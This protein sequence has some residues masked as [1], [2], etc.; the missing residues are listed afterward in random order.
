[1]SRPGYLILSSRPEPRHQLPST[2][3]NHH[4]HHH[5]NNP[6]R[7]FCLT[8]RPPICV[9]SSFQARASLPRLPRSY[10]NRGRSDLSRHSPIK[11]TLLTPTSR[12]SILPSQANTSPPHPHSNPPSRNRVTAPTIK[13]MGTRPR[14]SFSITRARKKEKHGRYRLPSPSAHTW[15]RTRTHPL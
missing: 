10:Q 14:I 5:H 7:A 2:H 11:F 13:A 15:R 1:M 8:T 4:H 6:P 3:Y 12:R 9:L